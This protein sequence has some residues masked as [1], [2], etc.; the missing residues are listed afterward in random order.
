MQSP[1]LLSP[2]KSFPQPKGELIKKYKDKGTMSSKDNE[3]EEI[4]SDYDDD[5]IKLTGSMVESSKQKKLKKF[6]YVTKKCEHVHLTEE[7]IKDQKRLEESAKAEMAKKQ[8]EEMKDELIDLLGVDVVKKKGP[9]TLKVY[10]EDGSDEVI[11][12]FKASDLH[13]SEWR[14]VVKAC[15][16]RIGA[17]WS[18]L[19]GQI[20]TRMD[21][22]HKT[23]AELGIDLEKPL[24][25]HDPLDRLNELARKKR[26]H[27]NDI[28]DFF[29][30]TKK[31]KSSIQYGDLPAGTVLN[32]PSLEILFRLHQGPGID[33]HVRTFSSFLLAE[34]E[35][36]GSVAEPF[37][38]SLDLNIKSPKYKQTE[39][40]SACIVEE[41]SASVLRFSLV[42]NSKLNDVDLLLRRLKQN[43]SLLEVRRRSQ[44]IVIQPLAIPQARYLAAFYLLS[45]W[46][47]LPYF[48]MPSKVLVFLLYL[49]YP[50]RILT[51]E[52]GCFGTIKAQDSIEN[53]FAET[54]F[55]GLEETS[56][57]NTYRGTSGAE[58][59]ELAVA[60]M[61][62][63]QYALGD[64]VVGDVAYTGNSQWVSTGS[65]TSAVINTASIPE[66]AD[67]WVFQ[68]AAGV[69]TILLVP[70][71]PHGVLQLGSLDIVPEDA[72]MA[73][74][75]KSEFVVH[76]DLIAYSDA[77]A[78]NQQ[79][80]SQ[81]P[82]SLM[83]T[84][85]KSLD[86][87]LYDDVATIEDVNCSNH[88]QLTN[89]I[90]I[91]TCDILYASQLTEKDMHKPSEGGQMD[92][93]EL[94]EPL[95]QLTTLI[96]PDVIESSNSGCLEP[97]ICDVGALLSFPKE[98][99]LHKALV[100]AFMGKTDDYSQHL[101][102]GDDIY[103][104]SHLFS[105]DLVDS[106][107]KKM[108]GY[109][110]CKENV[111]NPLGSVVTSLHLGEYSS[112]QTSGE[113]SVTNSLGRYSSMVTRKSIHEKS[114]FEGETSLI[115]NH[116]AP[117]LYYNTTKN[118]NDSYSPSAITYEDVVDEL[119]VEEERKNTHDG[120][121]HNEGSK[122]SVASKRRGKPGA[123]Q[124]ARPRD[125][126]LIQDR[127][128]DLRELVPDGAKCSIDGLLD[129]SVKH[130]LF[131]ETVGDR[132]IKLRKCLQSEALWWL[133]HLQVM[134]IGPKNNRTPE[135]KGS[136]NGASWAYELRG[137]IKVCPILV[138][139]LQYP[140]HMI[141]EML[142]DESIRFLEIAEV[143]HGLDLTILNG[144]M[145]MCSGNTWARYIVEAP[146]EF[147]RLDIFWPL[148]KLLQLPNQHSPISSKI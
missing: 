22:L 31:Y 75:I 132:A 124:T 123:K 133:N 90:V 24:Q 13:L 96:N 84:M 105:E 1:F 39:D 14:E 25:E 62:N 43:I 46:S 134:G 117:A 65:K 109:L 115:N 126:Q 102:I 8:K 63:Y 55:R 10:R 95:H 147:H 16:N 99:E 71:I 42:E 50:V 73:D 107:S 125:R 3:E 57:C 27:A 141:I 60:Y 64:G 113:S 83:S 148:M 52:D 146:R 21:Y 68:F 87:L 116:V 101:P 37:S 44:P 5:A 48:H 129:R 78:T 49:A 82:S 111:R 103:T 58:A 72:K 140:G 85:M 59:V 86:E 89:G 138:E 112:I 144:A 91:P 88:K 139:D 145:E 7:Q 54:S 56:S 131:L 136:Q 128:K 35:V 45:N 100:P 70:V 119:A 26:K 6:D 30:S 98:C 121:N 41:T 108:N 28:H 130:M 137:D 53:M 122:P 135:D 15:S 106:L 51:W 81:S 80:S 29:R 67:E 61:S 143:I 18:T 23:E 9:I 38:L 118:Y 47:D 4:K 79:F 19:Y 20:K 97:L 32:E 93:F 17:G 11:T 92:A 120:L 66:H 77:F 142:C 94:T 76:Q 74:Y 104:S 36:V 110:L 114:T 127:L 2:P 40:S 34:E 69:K 33:D 12:D